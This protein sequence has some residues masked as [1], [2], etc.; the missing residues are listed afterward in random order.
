MGI[1]KYL[2]IINSMYDRPTANIILKSEKLK[3]SPLRPKTREGY[4][5]VTFIQQS[6]GSPS[7]NNQ[8]R[9][10]DKMQENWN[11]KEFCYYLQ[12]T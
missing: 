2:S 10:R 3:A 5:Q 4:I 9:K 7:H 8:N 6:I 12:M 11:E 1:K